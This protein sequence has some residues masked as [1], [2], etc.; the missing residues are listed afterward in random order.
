MV[1]IIIRILVDKCLPMPNYNPNLKPTSELRD[2]ALPKM[3]KL[4]EYGVLKTG[5]KL[6]INLAPKDSEA[7]LL[8]GSYVEYKGE[9]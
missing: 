1:D 5:D 4:I 2:N 8:G 7:V 6:Y 3:N 9:N